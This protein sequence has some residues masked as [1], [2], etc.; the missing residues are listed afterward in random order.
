MLL[1][2]YNI[3]GLLSI[4]S[5]LGPTSEKEFYAF[6]GDLVLKEGELRDGN[7][8]DRKPPEF[9]IHQ[10]ILLANAEKLLFASGLFYQLDKIEMF[11]D[12]YKDALTSETLLLFYVEN[13][14]DDMVVAYQGLTLQLL[15]YKDGMIWN[16]LLEELYLEKAD[17]K[18]QSAEDKVVTVYEAAKRFESKAT[19]L[20]FSDALEKTVVVEK[21]LASGPV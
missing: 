5:V 2:H 3:Q 19:A 15:P 16:D 17:L 1:E 11:V 7:E 14:T 8:R 4:T 12:K 9:V 10:A 18:G 20:S 21:D 6:R 13:I